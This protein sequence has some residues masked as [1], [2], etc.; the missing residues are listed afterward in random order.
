MTGD[1]LRAARERL[2][3]T[4]RDLLRAINVSLDKDYNEG[5]QGG[6]WETGERQVPDDVAAFV[7]QLEAEAAVHGEPP[8][9]DLP[10]EPGA[11]EPFEDSPPPAPEAPPGQAPIFPGSSAYARVCEELFEM[12]ATGCG[13]LG[14]V[15]DSDALKGDRDIILADKEALGR[16]YGKLA[17]TNETFRRMLQGMTGGGAWLEV[18]LVSGITL[19]KVQ[20]NHEA[21]RAATRERLRAE[22]QA[23]YASGFGRPEEPQNGPEAGGTVMYGD[24]GVIAFPQAD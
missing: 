23:A 15:L 12:V 14:V 22:E 4:R 10:P 3:W 13:L 7:R 1:E 2:G 20:K 9:A 24:G 18:A 5:R 21:A 6:R 11:G 19:G 17:E 8:P 16:A